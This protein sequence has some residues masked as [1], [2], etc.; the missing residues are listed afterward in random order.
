MADGLMLYS[1][2][3]P[4]G[5]AEILEHFRNLLR[6]VPLNRQTT[7]Q[8][9]LQHLNPYTPGALGWTTEKAVIALALLE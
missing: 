5:N 8:A 9:D 1:T 4:D 3:P 2:R 6:A 7:R